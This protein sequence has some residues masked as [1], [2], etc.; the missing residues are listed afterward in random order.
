MRF[1]F[2]LPSDNLTG[3]A[4]VVALHARELIAL[5][6]EVLV[7]S[8]APDRPPLRQRMRS[9]LRHPIQALRAREPATVLAGHVAL[10]GVPHRVLARPGPITAADVPDADVIVATWWETAV[11]MHGMPAS[12]GSRVHL[13]QG[14]E[15]WFG[16]EHV[17]RV[18]AALRL[19][20]IK[21]AISNDLRQTIEQAI[22]PTGMQV[23]PNALDGRQFDA[24]RRARQDPPVVGF[25]YA[26]AAIKGADICAKA[27]N[28]ARQHLPELQVLA[29]GTDLPNDAVPLPAGATFFHRP[30]QHMLREHY[31][32]CD[33]WLFGS[34]LDSFGLPILEAMACRTPVIAVPV[35]AARDLLAGGAGVL[36]PPESPQAMADQIV[37]MCTQPESRWQEQSDMAHAT[38]HAYQW[39][40][41]AQ[42]LLATLREHG[43]QA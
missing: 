38:A 34:R 22:G 9:A 35:G 19:P 13:I 6:H 37:R 42:L 21:I 40:D 25:V 41:A 12:K 16:P 5:G 17:P 8:C 29:F 31:A 30:K 10:S 20:N 27:C 15:V 4:R 28:L 11:W 33:A 23:V 26:H 36:V 43:V 32:A 1:T 39:K 2:L 24:P 7:V 18:D 3:G 14:Y